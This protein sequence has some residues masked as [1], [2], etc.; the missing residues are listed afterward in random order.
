MNTTYRTVQLTDLGTEIET[1]INAIGPV[2]VEGTVRDW[3]RSH[4]ICG[5]QLQVGDTKLRS[6][7]WRSV[8]RHHVTNGMTVRVVGQVEWTPRFGLQLKADHSVEPLGMST[9]HLDRQTLHATVA[10]TASTQKGLAAPKELRLVHIIGPRNGSA[11]IQDVMSVLEPADIEVVITRIPMNGPRV[12]ADV[13]LAIT[14]FDAA[15]CV[16]VIRGGGAA[17]DL[18]AF[19]SPNLVAAVQNHTTPIIAGIGHATNTS[20]FDLAVWRSAP[21][22]SLAA[23]HLV[24]LA[25]DLRTT[26]SSSEAA[27]AKPPV[28]RPQRPPTRP[29]P[30][31]PKPPQEP[32]VAQTPKSLNDQLVRDIA[33]VAAA[34]VLILIALLVFL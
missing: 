19:D 27:P 14:K 8:Q 34:F 15:D 2:I 33:V 11:A 1:A 22:P 29:S 23:H 7:V 16:L 17:S 5:F 13:T 28:Q 9:E 6:V 21:T 26:T 25:T 10:D 30:P 32:V 20:A 12:A 4:S 18:A 3:H 31:K 24:E